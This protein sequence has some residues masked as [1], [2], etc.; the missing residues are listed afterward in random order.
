MLMLFLIKLV[1][2]QREHCVPT[3]A[4]SQIHAKDKSPIVSR[5]LES[6]KEQFSTYG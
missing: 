4:E 5:S 2:I 1:L 6:I 3:R